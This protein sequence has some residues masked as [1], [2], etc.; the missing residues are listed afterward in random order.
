V[1]TVLNLLNI[2]LKG[3]AWLVMAVLILLAAVG[4]MTVITVVWAISPSVGICMLI[5]GLAVISM[6]AYT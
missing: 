3:I 6:V 5:F 2:I 1:R 4:Y